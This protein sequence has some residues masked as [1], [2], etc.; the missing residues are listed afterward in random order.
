L[1][2]GLKVSGNAQFT[3]RDKMLSHGTLL[4]DADLSRL[5]KA[6]NTSFE[7]IEC[8]ATPSKR[9]TVRNISELLGRKDL[10]ID[11]VKNL[12][13]DEIFL[14]QRVK[15]YEL[16]DYEWEKVYELAEGKYSQWDWNVGESPKIRFRKK[17][18]INEK[19]VSIILEVRKGIIESI[20]TEHSDTTVDIDELLNE[21]IGVKY[22]ADEIVLKIDDLYGKLASMNIK[23][24]ELLRLLY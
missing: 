23:K 5:S 4:F 17:S 22:K 10:S 14:K 7:I 3:S 1:I 9:S 16:T 8:K 24:E 20:E 2:D 15:V 11:D 13:I 21:I 6:L 12:I 18:S 19:I